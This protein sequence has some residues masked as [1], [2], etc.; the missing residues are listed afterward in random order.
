MTTTSPAAA[1]P[2][3]GGAAPTTPS[4][5]VR[6]T[7]ARWCV[8]IALAWA[9]LEG[10]HRIGIQGDEAA[11]GP[12]NRSV[13]ASVAGVR[14]NA[15][16]ADEFD[17]VWGGPAAAP[18]ADRVHPAAMILGNSQLFSVNQPVSGD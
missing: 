7:I 1:A 12:D 9:I 16:Q 4:G 13:A 11:L 10:Y 8:S 15:W 5:A 18:A 17:A 2:G 14:V 3:S 6:G